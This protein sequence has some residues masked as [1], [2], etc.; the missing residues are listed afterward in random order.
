M[1]LKINNITWDIKFTEDIEEGFF[2]YTNVYKLKIGIRSDMALDVVR[3]TI[4]HELIHAMIFSY[5]FIKAQ[6][7]DELL[8]SEEQVA[9]FIAM[10]L[11]EINKLSNKIYLNF[12]RSII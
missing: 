7:E 8:F 2:G 3:T 4:I 5:G 9:D 6:P 11:D 1:K 12:L 10:N